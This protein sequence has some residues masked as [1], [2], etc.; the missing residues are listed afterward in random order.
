MLI[1]LFNNFWIVLI[2]FVCANALV[3]KIKSKKYIA[4]NPFLKKGYDNF[5]KA[6]IFYC[7]IPWV[8]MGVG[9][10]TSVTKSIT[11][12]FNPHS[13]NYFVLAFYFSILVI[14]T[15]GTRWIYFKNGAIFLE[16]HPG[17]LRGERFGT[18]NNVNAKQIKIFWGVITLVLCI[19]VIIYFINYLHLGET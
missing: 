16:N 8:I 13:E 12:Y 15:L 10:T 3:L 6:E 2:L 9:N 1:L 19:R 14:W 18:R 11:D 17:L 5:I 4:N 7:N